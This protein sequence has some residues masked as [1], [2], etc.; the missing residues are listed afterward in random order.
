MSDVDNSNSVNDAL[1][2]MFF[3]PVADMRRDIFGDADLRSQWMSEYA[4]DTGETE[5]V[6]V[7]RETVSVSKS[8]RREYFR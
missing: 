1:A 5:E 6:P 4:I 2:S 8:R 7:K 3:K